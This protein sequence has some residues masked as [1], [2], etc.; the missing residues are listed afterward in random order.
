MPSKSG[1]PNESLSRR[2]RDPCTVPT[3]RRARPLRLFQALLGRLRPGP[4]MSQAASSRLQLISVM[5]T[6]LRSQPTVSSPRGTRR[7]RSYIRISENCERDS[8]ST[9]V[10]APF[11]RTVRPSGKN[12][13][14]FYAT[15]ESVISINASRMP[16]SVTE[17]PLSGQTMNLA[18]GQAR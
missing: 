1:R 9:A 13:V 12:S 7:E 14:T 15:N 17:C 18:S 11:G 16:G 6:D 5:E 2:R 8:V 10:N 3:S 4:S